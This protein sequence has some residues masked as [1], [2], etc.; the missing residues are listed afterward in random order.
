M[1]LG[2]VVGIPNGWI[3]RIGGDLDNR[4][5]LRLWCH[6]LRYWRFSS[7]ATVS[8]DRISPNWLTKN[9]LLCRSL[10]LLVWTVGTPPEKRC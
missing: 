9:R 8:S 10:M 5:E 6:Y 3:C 2:A 7:W 4:R 1:V